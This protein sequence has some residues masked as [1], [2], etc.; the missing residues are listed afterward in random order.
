MCEDVTFVLVTW[1]HPELIT[2]AVRSIREFYPKVPVVVLDNGSKLEHFNTLVGLAD[3]CGVKLLRN[4]R[5]RGHGPA[6]HQGI[7]E[8]VT[9]YVMLMDSDSWLVR[10]GW[11]REWVD[12]LEETGAYGVGQVQ[13]VNRLGYDITNPKKRHG[14]IPYGHPSRVLLNRLFYWTLRPACHHGAPMLANMVDAKE[15]GL[16]LIPVADIDEFV[17]HKVRGT[18]GRINNFL[19]WAIP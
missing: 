13:P 17:Q 18:R 15:E 16:K 11:L 9:R 12:R 3:E 1:N 10:G 6:L 4:N 7:K 5:N 8:A 2:R 19:K 14:G